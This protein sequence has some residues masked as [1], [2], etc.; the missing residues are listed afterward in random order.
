MEVFKGEERH[1]LTCKTV[2]HQPEQGCSVR[3]PGLLGY[4]AQ[5]ET[6]TEM[7]A[8]IRIAA[9]RQPD[10]LERLPQG[11]EIWEIEGAAGQGRRSRALTFTC[12]DP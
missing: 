8:G 2:L 6:E 3:K 1:C 7:F 11:R 9:S 12:G 5:G 4:C 10:A